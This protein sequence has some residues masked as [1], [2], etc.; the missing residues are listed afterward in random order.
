M[1]FAETEKS[2]YTMLSHHDIRLDE[3][4]YDLGDHESDT[5][6]VS[7]LE[8]YQKQA[9]LRRSPSYSSTWSADSNPT[10]SRARATVRLL[11][12]LRWGIVV[13]LQSIMIMLLLW[14]NISA[15]DNE[16]QSVLK[17]KVVETGGDINGLYK[18]CEFKCSAFLWD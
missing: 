11:T 14:R 6:K 1:P 4:E 7:P 13:G 18:T 16:T 17:G 9:L 2:K 15:G 12:W 5:T 3:E 8:S 10:H